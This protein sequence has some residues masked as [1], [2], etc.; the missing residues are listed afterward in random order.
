MPVPYAKHTYTSSSSTNTPYTSRFVALLCS[1]HD[2][3]PGSGWM[4]DP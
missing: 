2:D 4:V 3:I 1:M